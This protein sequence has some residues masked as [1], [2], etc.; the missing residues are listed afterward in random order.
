ML[1]MNIVASLLLSCHSASAGSNPR[2][3]R[4]QW[5]P[6]QQLE[7]KARS[8]AGRPHPGVHRK[9]V[10]G[11]HMAGSPQSEAVAKYALGC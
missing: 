7:Q 3:P 1:K 8:I 6:Q 4:T 11:A 2:Y 10:C 9:D 5:Y